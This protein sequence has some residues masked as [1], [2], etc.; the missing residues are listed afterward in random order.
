MKSAV[1]NGRNSQETIQQRQQFRDYHTDAI[2]FLSR[3]EAKT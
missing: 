1:Y 2:T 3:F